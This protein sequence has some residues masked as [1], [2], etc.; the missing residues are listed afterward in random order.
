[1]WSSTS[2][3]AP[4]A[5]LSPELDRVKPVLRTVLAAKASSIAQ[6]RLA[7][8]LVWH[9]VGTKWPRL[10]QAVPDRERPS[11]KV[12]AAGAELRVD[13]PGLGSW[14][15]SVA[16]RERNGGRTWCTQAGMSVEPTAAGEVNVFSVQ[17]ACTP[18]DQPPPVLALPGVLPLWLGR[19]DLDDDGCAVQGQALEVAEDDQRDA[20]FQ[21]VLSPRRTLPILVLSHQPRSFHFGVDPKAL[22][23]AVGG[24]AHVACLTSA[25][26]ADVARRWGADLAPV[27][28]AARLYRPGFT[29]DNNARPECAPLWR[30]PRPA[31]TA[32]S[33]DPGAYR[34]WLVQKV[35]ETSVSAPQPGARR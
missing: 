18:L 4:T 28:G 12:E 10:L 6:R 35:C 11:L 5:R 24:L 1:M 23:L 19:L 14:C 13:S 29:P 30:D 17:T 25:I 7:Q 22:A 21:H 31:G 20:F 27:P 9:W 33:T 3:L 32:R 34:R 8:D 26:R 2:T 16:H 15:L